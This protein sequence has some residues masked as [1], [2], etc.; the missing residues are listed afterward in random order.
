MEELCDEQSSR[1]AVGCSEAAALV[2][3]LW[4]ADLEPVL[5]TAQQS[6]RQRLE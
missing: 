4:E 2:V 3:L 5:E 6:D 1:C